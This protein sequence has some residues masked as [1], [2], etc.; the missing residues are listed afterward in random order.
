MKFG[1]S[2][3]TDA[4]T[5]NTDTDLAVD[6]AGRPLVALQEG[7]DVIIKRFKANGRPDRSFGQS[8]SVFVPCDCYLGSLN[9]GRDRKLL[10]IG[11]DEFKR[12]SPFSGVTWV[13]ARLRSD[14][15]VD[16]GFGGDGIVRHPMPGFYSPSAQVEPDGGALLYGS[17]CCRF[18]S[19]PFIQR[20]SKRGHLRRKYAA[21]TKR[22]LHGLYG[23]R[24]EDL[25][26]DES[27][28]VLR[29]DGR[30]EVFGGEYGHSV[31]IRLLRN[32]ERDPSFGLRGVRRLDFGVSDAIADER[33]GTLVTGRGGG[34]KMM[35][36]RHD[37]RL[38]RSFGRVGLPHAS[39]EEGVQIF[40][41]GRG[42]AL[43]FDRGIPFCRQGCPAEPKL[44]RVIGLGA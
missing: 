13:M 11:S 4:G 14:G 44:F 3:R 31:A 18:P 22:A 30:V 17:V 8:G 21:A 23:T 27:A 7:H 39:N 36:L 15:S 16:R 41:Q 5:T 35:R 38:D 33:G 29:P 37:G 32:G 10:L 40:R 42:G 26:W 1:G 25:G 6:S 9:I 28:V 34:Y 43:V 19:K 12:T 24:K 20:M 2:G